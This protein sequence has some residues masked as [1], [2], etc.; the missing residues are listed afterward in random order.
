MVFLADMDMR[1]KVGQFFLTQHCRLKSHVKKWEYS[2]TVV[3]LHKK[4]A[5]GEI[6]PC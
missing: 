1:T 6:T 4:T 5:L 3:P 2:M